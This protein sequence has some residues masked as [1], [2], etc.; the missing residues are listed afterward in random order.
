VQQRVRY[1]S[2]ICDSDRWDAFELRAGDVV[3]TTPPKAGTTWMQHCCLHLIHGGPPPA[4]LTTIAPWIDQSLE[5]IGDVVARLDAQEHRRVVKTHT[6]MDGVPW[7]DD[8]TYIGVGRDPRDVVLSF[9]DHSTNFD[10]ERAA[11][12]RAASGAGE[13]PAPIGF[14]S[15]REWIDEDSPPQ[16][17]GSTLKFTAHHLSQLWQRR[18]RPNVHLF[19]YAEMRHDLPGQLRRLADALGV[20]GDIDHHALTFESMK[21]HAEETAPNASSGIFRSPERFF[22]AGRTGAWRDAFSAEDLARYDER[23]AELCPDPELR[24]WLHTTG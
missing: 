3:V 24:A 4:P 23:L 17:F 9:V 2:F 8:V 14:A 11:E 7:S 22:A 15:L 10:R 18:D 6:P 5:P 1:H 13:P 12:L 21:E 19:H 20:E 16:R